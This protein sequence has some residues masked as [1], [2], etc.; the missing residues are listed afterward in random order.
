MKSHR[1][2]EMRGTPMV[3]CRLQLRTVKGSFFAAGEG[4]G[5]EP[6]FK[7]ALDRL[8]RR[9]MRSKELLEYNPRFAK[10]YLRKVGMS[11]EEE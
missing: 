7:V 8:E 11:E 10:D 1:G 6:T 3:H 9:L 4:W 5:I 2:T